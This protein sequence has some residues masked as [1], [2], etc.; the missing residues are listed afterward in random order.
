MHRSILGTCSD[1]CR[2]RKSKWQVAPEVGAKGLSVLARSPVGWDEAGS[3]QASA[4]FSDFSGLPLNALQVF[5]PNGPEAALVKAGVPATRLCFYLSK[6]TVT[7]EV[8]P[9]RT[10]GC[11]QIRVTSLPWQR[12]KTIGELDSRLHGF[13]G[14]SSRLSS[15]SL[16]WPSTRDVPSRRRSRKRPTGPPQPPASLAS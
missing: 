3:Q 6:L 7:E 5:S 10:S 1:V 9:P 2:R 14:P 4:I 16:P 12:Y 13:F 8:G 15:T 11:W